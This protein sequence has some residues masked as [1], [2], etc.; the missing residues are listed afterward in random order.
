MRQAKAL[1]K[2]FC[3]LFIISS[4]QSQA[5]LAQSIAA[6]TTTTA[7]ASAASPDIT[8]E[9]KTTPPANE[10]EAVELRRRIRELEERLEKLETRQ[11]Q[12]QQ[13]PEN[14]AAIPAAN[15]TITNASLTIAQQSTTP[16]ETS[17]KEAAVE[18]PAQTAGA[19]Q[20]NGDGILNF[21][22]QVEV[23]GFIDGYY[24]YNFNKPFGRTNQLRSYETRNNEF[25]LNLAE[26]ALEK[27]P[28]SSSRFGF[29]LDLN[30]GPAADLTHVGE[31][32]NKDTYKFLQQAYGSYL[33]PVGNGLQVDVGKFVTWNGAEVIE[34]KDN[35]NYSRGLLFTLGPFYHAGARAKYTFNSKVSLLAAVVN[36]WDTTEDNNGGKTFGVQ[37]ALTPT[38]KFSLLQ[39]YN[40]GPEEVDTIPVP[41]GQENDNFLRHYFD[42]VAIYNFN[43]RWSIMANYDYGIERQR[44][45][46][47]KVHFQGIATYLRYSPTE[48]FSFSPRFEYYDD[49][50][51][52]RT[53]VAQALK[54]L[55]FTGDYKLGLGFLAR[56]ELRRDWSDQPFFVKSNPLDPLVKAQT[57]VLGGLTWAFGTRNQ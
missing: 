7:V 52:A 17:P 27:K 39:S 56:L 47:A 33:L 28:D 1:F 45:T 4:L 11:Q 43:P 35:Y 29:R 9:N 31:F 32:G 25:A 50:N 57:N 5:L 22:K 20:S 42:T 34:S 46:G 24:S 15:A 54:S 49:Y 26:I 21:F 2:V 40:V 18:P 48:R 37:L 10:P 53:G 3:A 19:A 55:T 6:T 14:T 16:T 30:Y 38:S 8:A 44:L 13:P 36:G 23:T 51:G 12:P 41:T